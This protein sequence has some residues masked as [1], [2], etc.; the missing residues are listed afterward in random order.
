MPEG[1]DVRTV[2][3]WLMA[4]L[5]AVVVTEPAGEMIEGTTEVA[6]RLVGT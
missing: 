2:V 1:V 5:V 3:A 6:A 4:G